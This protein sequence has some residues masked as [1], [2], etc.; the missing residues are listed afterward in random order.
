MTDK[1][2]LI[3]L[4]EGSRRPEFRQSLQDIFE[5]RGMQASDASAQLADPA[6]LRDISIEVQQGCVLLPR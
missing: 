4:Q 3:L 2:K 5:Q 1:F 6:F